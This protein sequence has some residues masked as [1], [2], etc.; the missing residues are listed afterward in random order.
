MVAVVLLRP[1][2][3]ENVNRDLW[4]SLRSRAPCGRPAF[5]RLPRGLGPGGGLQPVVKGAP[6][7]DFVGT[8][9]LRGSCSGP[10]KARVWGILTFADCGSAAGGDP[11]LGFSS[12]SILSCQPYF[13]GQ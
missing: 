2:A 8:E 5:P 6:E 4:S 3:V 10:S 7:G 1:V 11:H 12:G 9:G 13:P